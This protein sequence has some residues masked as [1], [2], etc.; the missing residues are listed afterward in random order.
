M[1]L[2][3]LLRD[4]ENMKK[5]GLLLLSLT[6]ILLTAYFTLVLNSPPPNTATEG[7]IE[8]AVNQARHLYTQRKEGKMDFSEG[9]CISNALMPGWVV[10]IAH[11]PRQSIDD[12]PQNQCA[13]FLEGRAKH[14]VELDPEGDLIRAQ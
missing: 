6:V 14:F 8:T 9:P 1:I 10:D 12:L 4:N 3:L 13:A 5:K 7:E 2:T 11:R